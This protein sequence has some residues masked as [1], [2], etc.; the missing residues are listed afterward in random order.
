MTFSKQDGGMGFRELHKFNQALLAN[1]VWKIMHHPNSLVFR[2]LKHRY[3]RRTEMLQAGRGCQP[4]FG[5]QSLL[6]GK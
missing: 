5:W 2:A 4:S 3:F 6:F 1:Q